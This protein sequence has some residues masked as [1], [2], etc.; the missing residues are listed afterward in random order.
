MQIAY[1]IKKT[2]AKHKLN[3]RNLDAEKRKAHGK[4][5]A[6]QRIVVGLVGKMQSIVVGFVVKA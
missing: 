6:A 5:H 3:L 2:Y 4:K 1:A